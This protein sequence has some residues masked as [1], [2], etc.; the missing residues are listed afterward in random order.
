MQIEISTI[1]VKIFK[2]SQ[3]KKTAK[4]F[5]TYFSCSLTVQILRSYALSCFFLN[6]KLYLTINHD[7]YENL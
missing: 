1:Y 6:L 2:I 7:K 3:L 5:I 4:Q